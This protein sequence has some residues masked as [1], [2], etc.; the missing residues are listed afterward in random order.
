M[1]LTAPRYPS[2]SAHHEI[3][4]EEQARLDHVED[5]LPRCLHIVEIAQANIDIF[6]DGYD[7]RQVLHVIMTE[8]RRAL[9]Y[10][11]QCQRTRD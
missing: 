1:V 2:R 7:V 4:E 8:S 11:R 9:M 6:P 3:L 10:R 5:V